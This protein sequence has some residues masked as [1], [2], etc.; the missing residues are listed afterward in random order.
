MAATLHGALNDW[1]AMLTQVESTLAHSLEATTIEVADEAV[2]KSRRIQGRLD[3]R[4]RK[5]AQRVAEAGRSAEAVGAELEA[6]ETDLRRWTQQVASINS[7]LSELQA[8]N[9]AS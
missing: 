8:Q 5:L 6:A 9:Q 4:I 7:A 2:P 3:A 1:M